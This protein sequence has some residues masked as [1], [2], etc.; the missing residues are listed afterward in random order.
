VFAPIV[1]KPKSTPLKPVE[2]IDL[3]RGSRWRATCRVAPQTSR[4]PDASGA[5]TTDFTTG[6]ETALSWDFSKI[7]VHPPGSAQ[8]P[9]TPRFFARA[10]LPIQEKL[11]AGAID[12]PR[13]HEADRVAD[14]VF[15]PT[16]GASPAISTRGSAALGQQAPAQVSR[17][18]KDPGAPLDGRTRTFFE[19][20]FGRDF[21]H[22]RVHTGAAA[23]QSA[24]AIGAVAYTVGPDVVFAEGRYAPAT[25]S[26][27]RLL[28]HEL[29]HT[30]QQSFALQSPG[31]FSTADQEIA[32]DQAATSALAGRPMAS[33]ALTGLTIARQPAGAQG[34][35][36]EEQ[37]GHVLNTLSMVLASWN[38]HGRS[39]GVFVVSNTGAVLS[40][41]TMTAG[42]APT[43]GGP[44]P[45]PLSEAGAAEKLRF[46]MQTLLGAPGEYTVTFQCDG[47]GEMQLQKLSRAD[48]P[49]ASAVQ[50]T[51]AQTAKPAPS[52]DEAEIAAMDP[53]RINRQIAQI[54][55]KAIHD[56]GKWMVIGSMIPVGMAVAPRA[57]K[58]IAQ[59]GR[60]ARLS[61][62]K[63][64]AEERY[65]EGTAQAVEDAEAAADV[66]AVNAPPEKPLVPADPR[67][68]GF[69]HEDLVLEF[70][71]MN[72]RGTPNWYK[73]IDY[74][75]VDS[76]A[77]TYTYAEKGETITV[78]ERPNVISHKSTRITEPNKL[79]AK[80]EADV[81]ALRAFRSYRKGAFEIDGVGQRK[82]ILTFDEEADITQETVYALEGWRKNPSDFEF[83]WYV[84]RGN[85]LVDGPD[86]IHEMNLEDY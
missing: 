62:I 6:Q 14:R 51:P 58:N 72:F 3:A 82:L 56:Q 11:K 50:P 26:G 57:V 19:P 70:N 80:I 23:A 43:P 63:A 16:A 18:L 1:A 21:S 52:G 35:S 7:P 41:K 75:E 64:A 30:L 39:G 78:Y 84:I 81:E 17:A 65:V 76:A 86:F 74:Y 24:S 22:V 8:R 68:R 20:R 48:L 85:R 38:K 46:F 42:D 27:R 83:E 32:A 25:P 59:L 47:R 45:T 49:A 61:M 31:L 36:L 66:D 9:R 15:G 73:T 4:M 13:E 28:A 34:P 71:R 29:A 5:Q 40:V 67:A 37:G 44:T 2:A 10:R 54:G 33:P 79:E 53:R 60:E 12:D 55:G 77:K 69:A